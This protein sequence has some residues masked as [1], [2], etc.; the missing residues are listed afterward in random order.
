[1][2][3][4]SK[5]YSPTFPHFIYYFKL[6]LLLCNK[7]RIWYDHCCYHYVC[8]QC[9]FL[10]IDLSLLLSLEINLFISLD[11]IDQLKK[12]LFG[13]IRFAFSKYE[14]RSRMKKT[15]SFTWQNKNHYFDGINVEIWSPVGYKAYTLLLVYSVWKKKNKTRLSNHRREDDEEEATFQL[16]FHIQINAH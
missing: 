14:S 5:S 7:I 4:C 8:Y 2:Y 3:V 16:N 15:K 10:P 12:K 6:N 9:L 1:M 13:M 11:L